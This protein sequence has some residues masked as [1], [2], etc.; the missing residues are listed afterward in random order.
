MS[1]LERLNAVK[2]TVPHYWPIGSFIHHNPLKG[3]ESMHFKD[4]L[5][6]A[7]SIFGGKV[8]M[9]SPY[10][11]ELYRQGK[12][13][14]TIFEANVK[15]L[16]EKNGLELD[17]KSTI[18]FLMEIGPKWQ[19]LRNSFFLKKR[20]VDEELLAYLKA[21]SVF[22]AKKAWVGQLVEHM[23]LYEIND[24]LFGTKDKEIVEKDIIE[25]IARFLDEDQTTLTM[26]NR[27]M[28]MFEAFKRFE[29][30]TYEYD[31]ER[32]VEES[33]EHLRVKDV[34]SYLL[35]HLLKLHGWAGFIKYRSED[36]DYFSQQQYPSTLMEYMA[37]RLYY[38]RKAVAYRKLGNF[39]LFE[40]YV[41]NSCSDVIVKLLMHK[42]RLSGQCLDDL[43]SKVE[44]DKVLDKYV[45]NELHLD[46]MLIEHTKSAL[47]SDIAL[48][49][50][51]AVIEKI[52]EEK[53][54]V[55]LKSLEDSYIK[56]LVES[57]TG[58]EKQPEE[59]ALA[60]ATFCLDVRSEVIRRSIERTGP[61]K[62]FGAG[63]FLGIPSHSSNSTRRMS[64]SCRRPS[65]S[66]RTSFSRSRWNRRKSTAPKRASTRR[67]KRF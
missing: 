21:K 59:Q 57:I 9:G 14:M 49:K 67:P 44:A 54:Y 11:M 2:D 45:T 4:G 46:A 52:R 53:G 41:E 61:Y 12:I 60:S 63:G 43:E 37:V 26:P 42:N 62:T 47:K 30:F 18:T 22:D 6:K 39:D 34:E 1:V 23:T 38:E 48:T 31:A 25:Y 27:E 28:G 55:W 36:P 56:N 40:Q 33:L 10:F 19:S 13:D 15:Q 20:P 8:Y 29:N 32:Y 16:L 65:S 66:R 24:A 64:F 50:L 5:K 17:L 58:A 35:T 3:F 7:Q 51:A